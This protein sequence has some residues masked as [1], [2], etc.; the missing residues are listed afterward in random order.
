MSHRAAND[1]SLLCQ[2]DF[3]LGGHCEAVSWAGFS[4]DGRFLVT[5]SWDE[6]ARVWSAATGEWIAEMTGHAAPLVY[7]E[8]S[9]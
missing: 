7:A 2:C 8:F 4:N 1:D 6:T 5:C 9:N 3:K